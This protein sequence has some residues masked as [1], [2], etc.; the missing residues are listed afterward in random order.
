M[1]FANDAVNYEWCHII[2]L[3]CYFIV[4]DVAL[5]PTLDSSSAA[6]TYFFSSL[7]SLS[8][9]SALPSPRPSNERP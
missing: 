6:A 3:G 7:S 4:P 1:V 5:R 2:T 9:V 8:S